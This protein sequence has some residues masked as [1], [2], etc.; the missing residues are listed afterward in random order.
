MEDN[1]LRQALA[2]MDAYKDRVEAMSRQVQVL[3]VS[4]DEVTMALEAVKAF[5]DAKEGDEIMVPVGASSFIP[6]KVTGNRTVV[7]GIGSGISIQKTADES[8][9]YLESNSA[10][11]AEALKKSVE[12]LNES[13]QNLA[14]MN[15]AVQQEYAAR[16][17]S[18]GG[19]Q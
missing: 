4:L 13:Q 11:I 1:E 6:V 14:A 10:E 16:R 15:E 9:E 7:T 12:A 17:Q 3:R 8:I 18:M 2:L 5:K 19:I